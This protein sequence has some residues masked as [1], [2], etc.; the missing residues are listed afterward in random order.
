MEEFHVRDH[1]GALD[2]GSQKLLWCGAARAYQDVLTRADHL[3]RLLGCAEPALV[4]W[5]PVSSH[6]VVFR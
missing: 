2:E 5:L 1:S 6:D 3:D 4:E